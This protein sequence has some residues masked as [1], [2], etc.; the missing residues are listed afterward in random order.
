MTLKQ[1]GLATL[2]D[3][4]NLEI[5]ITRQRQRLQFPLGFLV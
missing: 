5:E 2:L 4:D 1:R 3:L